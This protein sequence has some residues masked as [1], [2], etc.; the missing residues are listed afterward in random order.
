MAAGGALEACLAIAADGEGVPAAVLD[1]ADVHV[2]GPEGVLA[3][4]ADLLD[5]VS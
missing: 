2:R 1:A 5:A 4:L 3:L